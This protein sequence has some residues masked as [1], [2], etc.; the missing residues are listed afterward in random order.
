MSYRTDRQRAFGLGASGEGVHHWW[1]QRVSSIALIPL[2]ILFSWTLVPLIGGP[3]DEIVA[4]F[5]NPFNALVAVLCVMA[6]FWHLKQGLQV[7]IEDYV[8]H[9]LA[10]AALS[11]I[12]ELF[13]WLFGVIGV[14]SVARMAFGG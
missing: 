5:G 14:F 9:R 13:C 1:Q 12:S 7:V 8:H 4:A 2:V 6:V 3:R 10:L 11:I